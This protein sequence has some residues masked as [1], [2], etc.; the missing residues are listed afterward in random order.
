MKTKN[1]KPKMQGIGI[2]G[3]KKEA[4]SLIR[5]R[6]PTAYRNGSYTVQ[7]LSSAMQDSP[8]I[9]SIYQLPKAS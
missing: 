6:Y 3:T 8:W 4:L 7:L 2:A 9:A 5:K 1:A